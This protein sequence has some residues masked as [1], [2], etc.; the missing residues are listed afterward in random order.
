MMKKKIM[1]NVKTFINATSDGLE[2]N[3]LN[4]WI[5]ITIWTF[6]L[7]ETKNK[8]KKKKQCNL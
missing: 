4:K 6:M 2:N 5:Y 3:N 8:T 1:E 7:R